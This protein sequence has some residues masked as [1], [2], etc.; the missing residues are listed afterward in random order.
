MDLGLLQVH[1]MSPFIPMSFQMYT[2]TP[3]RAV[4]HLPFYWITGSLCVWGGGLV[5]DSDGCICS[6][7]ECFV[8]DVFRMNRGLSAPPQRAAQRHVGISQGL[9]NPSTSTAS[10]NP[11]GSVVEI[12]LQ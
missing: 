10:S 11:P 9:C 5:S 3:V 4:K 2:T 12:T 8:L 6:L 7:T 1:M